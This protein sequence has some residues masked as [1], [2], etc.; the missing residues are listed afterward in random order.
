ME[1][2]ARSRV[3]LAAAA[4]SA[5]VLLSA[6]AVAF[7]G[8]GKT[9]PGTD[10]PRSGAVTVRVAFPDSTP[11]SA[12]LVVAGQRKHDADA[13]GVVSIPGGI[14][15]AS[16]V[17]AAD[18]TRLEGGFLGLFRKTVRYTAFRPVAPSGGAPVTI[19]LKLQPTPD[20][21]TACKA[22]HPEKRTSVVPL[23]RCAHK[24]GIP[25]KQEQAD[26]VAR[27]NKEN[28]E[29]KKAG[30]TSYPAIVLDFRKKGFLSEKVPYLTCE[31]CH[32]NHVATGTRQYVLMPFDEMSILC[33]GCH[34]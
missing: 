28:E 26:R 11:A 33:R 34:V 7:N 23:F 24:S 3:A 31:S 25:V 32:S 30:K 6:G 27:F 15:A 13:K 20:I 12:A 19:D 2:T 8:T 22:C 5:V 18:V 9:T 10:T 14:P 4:F 29:M 21:D 16:G 1:K 17:A